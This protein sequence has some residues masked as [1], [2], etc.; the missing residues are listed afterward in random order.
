MAT[1]T[2]SKPATNTL[3]KI[4][5]FIAIVGAI[6]WGLIGLFNWN[7]VDALFGGGTQEE[8]S[9]GSRVVYALVG[10]AG[11]LSLIPLLSRHSDLTGHGAHRV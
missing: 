9:V 3:L 8:T 10:L 5:L 1:A 4:V 11:L 6:N 2:T 7:L